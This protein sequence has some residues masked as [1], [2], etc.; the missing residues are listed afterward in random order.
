MSAEEERLETPSWL[1]PVLDRFERVG[2]FEDY[3]IAGHI[4]EAITK[5]ES[6]T[7]AEK[8]AA[9]AERWAFQL[10]PQDS[11]EPS[12]WKTH[13]GPS[14]EMGDARV[15]DIT[16]INPAV[17]AYWTERMAQAKH[18]LLRAR[19]ADLVWDL[20]KVACNLKPP[21]EAARTAVDGYAACAGLAEADSTIAVS[22]K[23]QRALKIALSVGDKPRADNIRNALFDLFSRVNET[24][25]WLTLFD[26][27]EE[28]TKIKFS[29]T[30]TDSMIAGLES[31][32]TTIA[33]KPEGEEP[34][35]VF[36]VAGRLINYYQ[37][38]G[39]K[40]NAERVILASGQ[41]VERRS[42]SA[43]HT[44]AHF[45]LDQVFRFY[46]VHGFDV[47]AERIQI[48]AR[49]R[50]EKAE[51]EMKSVAVELEI[52]PED[53]EKFL[54]GITEGGLDQ[55]LTNI[56]GY[57]V[58]NPDELRATSEKLRKQFPLASM[59]P[60]TKVS[61]GQVVGNI[62]TVDSDPEGALLHEISKAIGYAMPFLEKALDRAR[63]R[64]SA[65]PEQIVGFLSKSPAFTVRFQG[66]IKLGVEAYFAGDHPKAIHLLVP[67]I[68]S[69]LRFLLTLLGRPANK[70]RRG[71]L[72]SMTEKTLTDILE[73]EPVIKGM[74]GEAAHVYVLS[75]LADPRGRN[76]RNRMSHGLMAAE[77]FNRGISDRVLHILLMLGT[78]RRKETTEARPDEPGGEA[79]SPN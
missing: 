15:P 73:H 6:T 29:S 27:V 56:A 61:E 48:L 37:R 68:E 2:Y 62:G 69:A 23:L 71:D 41:A 76:L 65:T 43:N 55:A 10:S 66:I 79:T 44:V 19:Y 14:M 72:S 74:M 77:E 12:C 24:W 78:I 17:I 4:S 67:Q 9:N 63:E 45:W 50:G 49:Q 60:I 28:Q 53:L 75:F 51:G 33:A 38:L 7:E 36:S 1:V 16:W 47:E 5:A 58:P 11:G 70:A 8:K 57:F 35:P 21:I 34:G 18:P 32:V 64:Y 46:R 3:F 59:I 26:I 54:S 39:G 31:Y 22:D 52:P 13:F 40:A 25:G 42:A 30:Q 20:S